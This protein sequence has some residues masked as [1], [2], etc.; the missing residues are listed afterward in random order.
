M[1][2]SA[3]L[4]TLP[5]RR[6]L[7]GR[8][9]LPFP[10]VSAVNCDGQPASWFVSDHSTQPKG[11]LGYTTGWVDRKAPPPGPISTAKYYTSV[12]VVCPNGM[13]SRLFANVY[14][15]FKLQPGQIS[16][17]YIPIP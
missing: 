6:H 17:S 7:H 8:G 10:L 13:G 16:T 5:L 9:H 14:N 1:S 15:S 2:R 11:Y 3:R 12:P 4:L